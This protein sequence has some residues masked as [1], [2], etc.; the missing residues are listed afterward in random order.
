MRDVS[1]FICGDQAVI[2]PIVY[3]S[4][5]NNQS[6]KHVFLDILFSPSQT[7]STKQ[8]VLLVNTNTNTVLVMEGGIRVCLSF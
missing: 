3:K 4:R 7:Y 6:V 2:V 5:M 1:Q 8:D